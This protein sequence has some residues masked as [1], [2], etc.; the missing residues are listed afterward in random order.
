MP[1]MNNANPPIFDAIPGVR[2]APVASPSR[3][4]SETAIW[5]ATV[6]PGIPGLLHHMTREE[7]ILAVSGSGLVRI[8]E[9]THTLRPGDAFAVPAFTDFRLECEGDTPFEA[10]VVLPVGGRGVIA[11]QPAFVPPW[12]V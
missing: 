6:A 8:G 12:S 2:F 9:E 4:T 11:G 5:R 1:L 10:V 7:L 3:G